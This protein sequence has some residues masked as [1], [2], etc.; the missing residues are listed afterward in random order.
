MTPS[1]L[2]GTNHSRGILNKLG[3]DESAY[4]RKSKFAEQREE[5]Q[6]WRRQL[7]RRLVSM[8]FD[9]MGGL[10]ISQGEQG[11]TVWLFW[12]PVR[13]VGGQQLQPQTCVFG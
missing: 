11:R 8:R 6:V 7:R 12:L 4:I 5:L 2:G 9:S 1:A 13:K 10:W 3:G